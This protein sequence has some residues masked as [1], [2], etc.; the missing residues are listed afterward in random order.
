VC[1]DRGVVAGGLEVRMIDRGVAEPGLAS[2][3]LAELSVLCKS[4]LGDIE[5]SPLAAL[6]A[7]IA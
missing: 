5:Q 4:N 3:G 7:S 6:C 1:Q 2:L